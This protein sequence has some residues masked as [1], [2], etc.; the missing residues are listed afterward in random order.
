MADG[1]RRR[2]KREKREEKDRERRGEREE[3]EM[4][5][6][7]GSRRHMAAT[8]VNPPCKTAG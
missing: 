8:S 2:K 6:S 7:C 4:A 3:R 5:L 1:S